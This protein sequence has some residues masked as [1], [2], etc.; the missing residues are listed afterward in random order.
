MNAEGNRVMNVDELR[1]R[2]DET[3]DY[4]PDVTHRKMF[5]CYA[6]FARGAIY[7]LVWPPARIGLRLSDPTLYQELLALP[8]AEQWRYSE[9]GKPVNHW[10]L[11]PPG[12]HEDKVLLEKWVGLAHANALEESN[13][14]KKPRSARKPLLRK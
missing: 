14:P 13:K 7:A 1:Q 11:V 6:S 5:G 12:F 4:L 9:G 8:G 10:L 3:S 2:L